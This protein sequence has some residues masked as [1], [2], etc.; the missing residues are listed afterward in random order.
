M[1]QLEIFK[2]DESGSRN[3]IHVIGGLSAGFPSP[4]TDYTGDRIDLNEE[5]IRDPANTYYARVIGYYL[6]EGDLQ[7]GDALLFDTSLRPRKGDLAVCIIDGEVQLKYIDRKQGIYC[8]IEG[9]TTDVEVLNEDSQSYVVG[10]VTCLFLL[11]RNK[12]RRSFDGWTSRRS[13]L[14][15]SDKR[16]IRWGYTSNVENDPHCSVN[17]I[18]ELIPH[19]LYTCFG[20][21][22]GQSLRE[23]SV[24]DGDS[25]IIDRILEPVEGDLVVSYN[26]SEFMMKYIEVRADG[27]WLIP[28]NCEY[29]PIHIS[30]EEDTRKLVWGIVTYSIKQL[31][32]KMKKNVPGKRTAQN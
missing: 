19:P 6:N 16:A 31:R 17:L 32:F 24:D 26:A 20:R 7:K 18:E 30:E 15:R 2:I 5:L 1:K 8:L 27:I 25:V 11:R 3:Y 12:G 10:I 28:G 23:D 13:D 29:K 4:A 9:A 21:T 14:K 22:A